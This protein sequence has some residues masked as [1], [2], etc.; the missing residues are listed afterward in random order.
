M[1]LH[2]AY[3][4]LHGFAWP[5]DLAIGPRR[6]SLSPRCSWFGFGCSCLGSCLSCEVVLGP[7]P[8]QGLTFLLDKNKNKKKTI[9]R[10]VRCL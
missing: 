3:T 5:M 7:L 4:N 2:V 6:S 1:G 9:L 8:S 10:D